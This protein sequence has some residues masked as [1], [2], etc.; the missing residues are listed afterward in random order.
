MRNLSSSP[1]GR[2]AVPGVNM[3]LTPFEITRPFVGPTTASNVSRMN[4]VG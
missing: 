3:L 4:C 2:V 1:S